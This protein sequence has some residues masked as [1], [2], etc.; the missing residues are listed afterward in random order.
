MG[1]GFLEEGLGDVHLPPP[2]PSSL[3]CAARTRQRATF[4]SQIGLLSVSVLGKDGEVR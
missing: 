1:E 3:S 2:S 4:D